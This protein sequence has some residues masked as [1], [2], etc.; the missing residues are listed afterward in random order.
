MNKGCQ[1]SLM[2]FMLCN[3]TF[4]ALAKIFPDATGE[5]VRGLFCQWAHFCR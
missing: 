3:L 4:L 1:G 2:L 5:I